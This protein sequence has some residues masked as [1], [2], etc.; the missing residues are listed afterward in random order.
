MVYF[1]HLNSKA[2]G[3]WTILSLMFSAVLLIIMLIGSIWVM[4][5]LNTNRMDRPMQET[6]QQP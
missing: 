3:G 2:E 6:T 4:F 1:L 5:H